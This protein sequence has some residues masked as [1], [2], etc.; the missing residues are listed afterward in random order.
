M[1]S[2]AKDIAWSAVACSPRPRAR[3]RVTCGLCMVCSWSAWRPRGVVGALLLIFILYWNETSSLDLGHGPLLPATCF[4]LALAAARRRSAT[5]TSRV[6]G[7]GLSTNAELDHRTRS[8]STRCL[9]FELLCAYA[10]G[11]LSCSDN[12]AH[13]TSRPV[14]RPKRW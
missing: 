7:G 1:P 9:G 8:A 14:Q 11:Q 5:A 13:V 2:M 3:C 12:G 10:G 4:A 6:K